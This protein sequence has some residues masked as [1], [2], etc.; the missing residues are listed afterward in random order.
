M[1][2]LTKFLEKRLRLKVNQEKSAVGRP[3]ERKFLGYSFTEETKPRT[4]IAPK[5]LEKLKGKLKPIWKRGRGQSLKMTIKELNQI[6]VG[7]I[8]YYRLTELKWPLKKLDS[9]IRR[10][11]RVLIW[12]HWKT[13]KTRLRNLLE[14]GVPIYV[15]KPN[16]YANAG[17]WKS[18]ALPGMH[19][20]FPNKTLYRWGLKSLLDEHRRFAHSL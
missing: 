10:R 4:R 13:P 18:A 19:M 16:A 15:A 14:R 2:S 17:P 1:E 6:L 5:S 12:R 3:W 11:I 7:W 9:W 8:S 20:A